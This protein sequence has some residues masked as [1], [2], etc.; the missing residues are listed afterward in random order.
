M[1]GDGTSNYYM[2]PSSTFVGKFS[3]DNSDCPVDAY[4]I[5]EAGGTELTNNAANRLVMFNAATS[6][7]FTLLQI[8]VDTSTGLSLTTFYI[9][10]YNSGG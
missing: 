1:K 8:Y 10:A 9:R 3:T 5:H 2:I 6:G 7:S 4:Q